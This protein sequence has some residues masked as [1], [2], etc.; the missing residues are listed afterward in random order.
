MIGTIL[1]EK[2]EKII[3]EDRKKILELKPEYPEDVPF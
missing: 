1:Q 2:I 3:E